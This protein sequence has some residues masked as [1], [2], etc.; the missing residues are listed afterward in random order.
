M[1]LITKPNPTANGTTAD[2][3]AVSANFDT[4]Y[5]EFNGNIDNNN[6]KPNAGIVD[7]K[8]ATIASAGKVNT[9]SITGT[10]SNAQMNIGIGAYNTIALDSNGNLPAVS[11]TNLVGLK[12][13]QVIQANGTSDLTGTNVMADMADMTLTASVITGDS[14]VIDFSATVYGNNTGGSFQLLRNNAV[15]IKASGYCVS[16]NPDDVHLQYVDTP[17]TNNLTYK[18]QWRSNEDGGG[19]TPQNS[20]TSKS[21]GRNLRAIV[22][23]TPYLK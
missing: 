11:A 22:F 16:T 1:G 14:V 5:A 10:F 7:T 19:G 23:K 4:I 21:Q 18:I 2:G 17:T 15:L 12:L 8:L 20:P 13:F 3:S 9:T 6:I